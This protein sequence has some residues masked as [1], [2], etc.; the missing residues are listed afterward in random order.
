MAPAA[1]CKGNDFIGSGAKGFT[2]WNMSSGFL[3]R[4]GDRGNNLEVRGAAYTPS[5]QACGAGSNLVG[6]ILSDFD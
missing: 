3:E 6:L 4:I 5:A 1:A 2:F